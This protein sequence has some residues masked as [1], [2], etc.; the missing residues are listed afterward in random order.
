[1]DDETWVPLTPEQIQEDQTQVG[2]S[3][4]DAKRRKQSRE[5]K[6]DPQALFF[7]MGPVDRSLAFYKNTSWGKLNDLMCEA[8]LMAKTLTATVS[9]LIVLLVFSLSPPFMIS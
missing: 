4:S 2:S 7:A 3:T 8:G 6:M 9:L 1:M 5:T